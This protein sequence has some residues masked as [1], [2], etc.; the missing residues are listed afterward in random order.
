MFFSQWLLTHLH[1]LTLSNLYGI[2]LRAMMGFSFLPLLVK[3][4]KQDEMA[5]RI[6][7]CENND[8]KLI[9]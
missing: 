4:P 7:H 6:L 1:A 2:E 9:E 8:I 5:S 3:P